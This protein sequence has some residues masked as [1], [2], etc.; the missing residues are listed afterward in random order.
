[1][2]L[3]HLLPLVSRPSRY[4]GGEW[5]IKQRDWQSASVRI[6]L[7][8]PDL[9]EI[10]M[11]HQGLQIL[12]DL[13]NRH[14]DYLAE[15]VY[16]PAPDMEDQLRKQNVPLF[17]L[18]SRRALTDFDILGITLP[19]E[20]CVSNILTILDAAHI[21][22][23]AAER[24]TRFPLLIGGGPCSFNPEP[25]ADFFDAI[26]L[27]DGEEA[28]LEIAQTCKEWKNSGGDKDDL[29]RKLSGIQGLYIP[30]LFQPHY[31]EAGNFQSIESLLPGYEKVKKR[32]LPELSPDLAPSHPLVPHAKTV[33]D[34]LGVEIARGCTRGCRFC[35]AG[36]I[37]RPV[38]ERSPAQIL[39]LACR[40]VETGGFEE[41]ALLSLSTGDYSN[42]PNVLLPLMDNMTNQQVSVSLPSMRVGSLTQDIMEQ[43]RRVRKTGFTLAP[44]AG[45]DRLRRVI[46]KGIVEEDLLEASKAAFG[47]GWKLLK[48][49]FMFG[50]PTETQEDLEAM[51]ELVRKAQKQAPNK[52]G[53][54][55]VSVATFVP[56]SHTP[57]QWEAQMGI[58]EAF[59][60][61][62]YLKREINSKGATLKW[63]DPRMSFL[64]G[65]F[66]RGDRRL[67]KV[68]IEAWQQGARL[69]SWSDHFNLQRW[70]DAAAQCGIALE[71]YLQAREIGGPL[72]WQH[73]DLGFTDDFLHDERQNSLSETYTPDCRV[74]GCQ[75]CGLCDFK[76]IKPVVYAK[77]W[78][79]E[80]LEEVNMAKPKSHDLAD[81]VEESSAAANSDER[82]VYKIS[83][84]RQN[85]ARF[86]GHLEFLQLFFRACRR[87]QL[88]LAF[89]KGFHPT[90]KVSFSPALPLGT[91]SLAEYVLVELTELQKDPEKLG[92][93][94][95]KALP[96]SIRIMHVERAV[97]D[98]GDAVLTGY[99]ISLK[100]T[101]DAALLEKSMQAEALPVTLIRKKKRRQI[102]AKP[103]VNRL[104]A[105]DDKTLELDLLTIPGKAGIKPL[106]LIKAFLSLDEEEVCTAMVLKLWY[107]FQKIED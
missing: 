85:E 54:I 107:R 94:L 105:I 59:Q 104:I 51:V 91:A 84:S 47:L 2:N 50:L 52:K 98:E 65:V 8:F 3:D 12:Y 24:D 80:E 25:V 99:R 102:D 77:P 40:G 21:P 34:R 68:V 6:A 37:Y 60:R 61:I 22:F 17:S 69:D 66:A 88:P 43:I 38:R 74:H 101:F 73:V 100:N 14:E 36:M 53:R 90:P 29:L 67:S 27:G 55:N 81:P 9:Y 76:T 56:K 62:D 83:Y 92:D 31:D 35:Q 86:L 23:L 20:L 106:E 42:L 89:S 71:P 13:V 64:E 78:L 93:L 33:H 19:Y 15:R 5:N 41:L 95:N 45:T 10:G 79:K 70:Q 30:A 97:K 58:E 96:Q 72:P 28:L 46:N 26:L 57:F 1:M 82:P 11:S 39:D 87:A 32:I 75:K 103:F 16:A 4:T 63:N 7:A 48:F 18:E 49:Y 44:E